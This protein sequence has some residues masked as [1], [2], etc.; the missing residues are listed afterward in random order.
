MAPSRAHG[1][2]LCAVEA[3]LAGIAMGSAE[4][5]GLRSRAAVLGFVFPIALLAD[6]SAASNLNIASSDETPTSNANPE[7]NLKRIPKKEHPRG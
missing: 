2:A 7:G 3:A 5:R 1:Y 6:S 4:A